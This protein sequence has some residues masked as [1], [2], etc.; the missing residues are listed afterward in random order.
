MRDVRVK[1]A[2]HIFGQ[3][4]LCGEVPLD[5]VF[6]VA[7]VDMTNIKDGEMYYGGF[8]FVSSVAELYA[9]QGLKT[10]YADASHM[11]GKGLNTHGTFYEIGTY[12]ANNSLLALVAGHGIAPGGGGEWRIRFAEAAAIPGFDVPGRT[13]IVDLEKGLDT[14]HDEEIHHGSKF[15]DERHVLK[16]ML[17][18]LGPKEKA[19][20]PALFSR[21]L[22]APS[23]LEVD[24]ITASYGPQQKAYL[25]KFPKEEPYRAYSPGLEDTIVTSQGAES[26]M[27]AAL[28]N[29][30]RRVEPTAMLKL[31]AES[32]GRK[33]NAQKVLRSVPSELGAVTLGVP[34]AWCMFQAPVIT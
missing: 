32:Q 24:L 21:A 8:T 34:F 7:G 20:G 14:A 6:D 11:E 10:A 2:K 26:A 17:K 9:T 29:K 22:W 16:N 33:F 15:N 27:N 18:K 3:L 31:I 25:G 23:P 4:K 13:T 28:T 12:S 5:A 30:I 1:A 19:T